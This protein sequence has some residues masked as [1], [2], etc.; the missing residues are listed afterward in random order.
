MFIWEVGQLYHLISPFSNDVTESD[1][2]PS[3][4]NTTII[5]N[6]SGL[7]VL[8]D[9]AGRCSNQSLSCVVISKIQYVVTLQSK[10]QQDSRCLVR[11]V[12]CC[13]GT[14][15]SARKNLLTAKKLLKSTASESTLYLSVMEVFAL[16]DGWM[17]GL[18]D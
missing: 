18:T 4:I 13:R 9:S 1:S 16:M 15:L 11:V 14:S 10:L 7:A 5:L 17:D 12:L 8:S 6:M 2:G 3:Q